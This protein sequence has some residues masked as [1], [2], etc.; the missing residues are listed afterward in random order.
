MTFDEL[1]P[2]QLEKAKTCTTVEE[3]LALADAEG[4]ALT[5]SELDSLSGGI[6]WGGSGKDPADWHGGT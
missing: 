5:D 6:N 3:I 1:T 2:E 4:I